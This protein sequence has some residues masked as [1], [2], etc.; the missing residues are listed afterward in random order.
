[1]NVSTSTVGARRRRAKQQVDDEENATLLRLGPEFA[2]KQYDHDGNE[3]DLIALSLSESRL[4]IREALKARSRARNGGVDLESSNGE[5]DDDELA[6]VT[7]GAVANG[8]VKK[9]LD[10]LNTFARFKDEETCTAVDQLLHNSSDC[11][12]LHPFEIAQLSSL[13]CEDV[14]EAITLIPSLASKKEV[15]LQRILDELNRLED[16]YK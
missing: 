8:V 10:Y 9:T 12:V 1:M 2:L 11:S 16:P 14:D 3:H 5:I 7:S 15:N 4:L 13:G 6:K